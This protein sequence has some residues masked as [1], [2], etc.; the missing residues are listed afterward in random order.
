MFLVSACLALLETSSGRHLLS[1][2][3]L[4]VQLDS[5]SAYSSKLQ[6]TRNPVLKN[7]TLSMLAIWT[8]TAVATC[9]GTINYNANFLYFFFLPL[10]FLERM[11]WFYF[12]VPGQNLMNK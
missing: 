7:S 11:S 9:I 10:T 12:C 2:A 1:S 5:I 3:I 6:D 8:V 4:T